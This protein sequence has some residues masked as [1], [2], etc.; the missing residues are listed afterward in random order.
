MTAASLQWNHDDDDDDDD[1]YF[2]KEVWC[3]LGKLPE[4]LIVAIRL[5][6]LW[7]TI[8]WLSSATVLL[9]WGVQE[10]LLISFVT[11]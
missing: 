5:N 8:L 10:S 1:A 3:P 6:F 11:G 9:E 4:W 2:M 7:P